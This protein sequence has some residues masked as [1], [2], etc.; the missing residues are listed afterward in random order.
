MRARDKK[1]TCHCDGSPYTPRKDSVA[2]HRKG[3]GV[4]CIHSKT[5]P[6]EEDYAERYGRAPDYQHG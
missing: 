1:R 4:W 6:T 5:K 2:P 3:S